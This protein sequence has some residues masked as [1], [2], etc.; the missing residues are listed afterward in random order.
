MRQEILI[1]KPPVYDRCVRAFGENA[2]V[3]KPVIWSWGDKIYNPMNIEISR[4]LLAHEAVHGRRQLGKVESWWESYLAND[5]FRYE[6]ELV[7][8]RAEWQNW[9]RWHAGRDNAD[10]LNA[11]AGRLASALYGNVVSFGQARSAVLAR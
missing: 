7:A 1:E 2:I 10:V 9:V 4:E 8:H 11:I 5:R 3:G 6:E